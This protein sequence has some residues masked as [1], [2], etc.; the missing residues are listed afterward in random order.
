MKPVDSIVTVDIDDDAIEAVERIKR[1]R[2]SFLPV[3]DGSRLMGIVTKDGIIEEA[4]RRSDR[5]PVIA[6]TSR[7]REARIGFWYRYS[8]AAQPFSAATR[9]KEG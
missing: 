1:Y 7:D 2:R 9:E 6:T 8:G 3:L 5:A 4:L